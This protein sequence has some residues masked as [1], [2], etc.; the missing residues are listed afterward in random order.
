VY[1]DPNRSVCGEVCG[2]WGGG[3]GVV[4]GRGWGVG[5]GDIAHVPFFHPLIVGLYIF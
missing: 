2:G 4:G 5:G 1:V 3:V